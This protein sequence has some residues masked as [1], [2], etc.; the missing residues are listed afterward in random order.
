MPREDYRVILKNGVVIAL[1]IKEPYFNPGTIRKYSRN[2]KGDFDCQR[3][4]EKKRRIHNK[5]KNI[6]FKPYEPKV[7]MAH[8]FKH[9]N[10]L[11]IPKKHAVS[12]CKPYE[13]DSDGNPIITNGRSPRSRKAKVTT[14]R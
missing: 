12:G 11:F 2:Q 5:H 8:F 14:A 13:T 6:S 9:D 10:S 4:I 7:K 1:L 3:C